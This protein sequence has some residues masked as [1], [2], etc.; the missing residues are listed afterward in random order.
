MTKETKKEPSMITDWLD[1][2]GAADIEMKHEKLTDESYDL[3]QLAG[4]IIELKYLPT[5]ETDMIKTHNVVKVDDDELIENKRLQDILDNTYKFNGGSGDSKAAHKDWITHVYVL[6][7]KHLPKK[8]ECRI[9]KVDPKN[10]V[11]FKE[12]LK[13]YLWNTDLSWYMPEDDFFQPNIKYA[14]CS[15]I[16]L[17]RGDN[18]QI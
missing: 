10:M 4:E 7:E 9:T 2:H 11:S 1:K 15:T 17:T 18:E 8:L 12:G 3:G 13:D 6:A 16:I 5:L 14:W